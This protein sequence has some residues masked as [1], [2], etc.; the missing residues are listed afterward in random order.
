MPENETENSMPVQYDLY[1]ARSGNSLRAA[2][3]LELSNL[4]FQKHELKMLN[5]DHK[6]KEF[7]AINPAGHVPVLVLTRADKQVVLPQSGAI[8]EHLLEQHCP[9]LVTQDPIERAKCNAVIHAAL[10]DIAVQNALA[11]YLHEHSEAA[12]F[13]FNRMLADLRAIFET[14]RADRFL[15]GADVTIADYAH[16]PVVYMREAQLRK[17]PDFDHVMDWLD[18]MNTDPAIVRA[19]AYSGI[20][21]EE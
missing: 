5:G 18:R 1:F 16:F 12:E 11:R 10:S 21:I 17:Q 6:S 3:A 20:Q 9:D 15:C 19:K 8:M 2:I 13:V 7:L 14:V 4:P